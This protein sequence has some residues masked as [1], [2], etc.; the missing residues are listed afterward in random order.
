[1]FQQRQSTEVNPLTEI[2]FATIAPGAIG[3]TTIVAVSQAFTLGNAG[4]A[5]PSTIALGDQLEIFAAPSTAL[6]GLSL[7][8][9]PTATP[10]TVE[11]YFQNNTGGS[12]TPVSGKYTIIATRLPNTLVS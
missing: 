3:N 5:S 6:N 1:M 8:A 7:S 9:F 10:G 11:V 2:S 12:I 4:S